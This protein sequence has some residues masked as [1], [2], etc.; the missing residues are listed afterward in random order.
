MNVGEYIKKLRIDAGLSQEELGKQLGVQRAAVQKWECGRVQNLKRDIIKKLSIIFNVP[1]A[2][3]IE[4]YSNDI[5]SDALLS[6]KL[7]ELRLN[8]GL[9]QIEFAKTFNIANGTVGNWE[10][11][12]REPDYEMLSRI[13][14][15]Y[16]VTID[17]LLG[18]D[19]KEKPAKMEKSLPDILYRYDE[20]SEDQQ[21]EV[22]AFM[23]FKL[24]QQTKNPDI[25][26]GQIAA[27]GSGPMDV[28]VNK[29]ASQKLAALAKKKRTEKKEK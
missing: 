24:A 23:E 4:V 13:A 27:Y 21:R 1:P 17:Y 7:K 29:E 16:G 2:S 10:T 28:P 14:D 19:Q 22:L 20:L 3:F 9:T 6:Q 26:I 12:K 11:G 15:F 25:I 18:R 5:Q 8:K